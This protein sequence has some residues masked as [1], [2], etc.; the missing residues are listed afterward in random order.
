[1]PAIATILVAIR[2]QIAQQL[3]ELAM[4]IIT[5]R[6]SPRSFNPKPDVVSFHD[7][8]KASKREPM[9][10]K[11]LSMTR[12]DDVDC[13]RSNGDNL[14]ATIRCHCFN[15]RRKAWQLFAPK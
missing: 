7:A 14:V 3:C 1:M 13:L 12:R 2:L 8:P 6:A 10:T 4:L 15:D 11:C 9:I 5:K